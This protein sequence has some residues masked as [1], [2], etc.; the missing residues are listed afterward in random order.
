MRK[1]NKIYALY[2][3]EQNVCDGTLEEIC[4]RTGMTMDTLKWMTRPSAMKRILK[5]KKVPKC[6]VYIGEDELCMN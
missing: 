5:R 4:K 6:L 3:G 2:V 1:S